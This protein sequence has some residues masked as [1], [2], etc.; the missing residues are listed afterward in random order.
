[1]ICLSIPLEKL[2]DPVVARALSDLMLGLGGN[3]G[4]GFVEKPDVPAKPK[5]ALSTASGKDVP[6]NWVDMYASLP[7]KT[8]RFV[9]VVKKHGELNMDEL[10]DALDLRHGKELGGIAGSLTRW[11]KK[12][13]V[14]LPLERVQKTR[15]GGPGWRWRN[16][17][18]S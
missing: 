14:A 1:M 12:W 2:T 3:N 9:D 17:S 11:S 5:P 10:V 8:R 18:V 15:T 6:E 13:G 4:D 16:G 7:N